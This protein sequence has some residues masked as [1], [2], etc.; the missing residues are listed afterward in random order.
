MDVESQR[1]VRPKPA[2][3]SVRF[4][5]QRY[6]CGCDRKFE[7]VEALEFKITGGDR[8]IL[9][10]NIPTSLFCQSGGLSRA[11]FEPNSATS[12]PNSR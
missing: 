4:C 11:T 1:L 9:T 2:V 10:G 12:H 3:L 5:R 8:Q 7:R 6:V